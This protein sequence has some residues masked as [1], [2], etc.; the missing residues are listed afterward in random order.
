MI[1]KYNFTH[2]VDHFDYRNLRGHS[3]LHFVSDTHFGHDKEFLYRKRGYE[4]IKE[5]DADL[6]ERWNEEVRPEDSVIH[7]GDF[8][9]GAGRDSEQYCRD[10]LSSLNGKI[11]L[12]WGNHNAGLKQIFRKAIKTNYG[13]ADIEVYPISDPALPNVVFVGTN[14]LIKVKCL[15]LINQL[16]NSTHFVFCSHYAH[17]IWIDMNQGVMHVCGHSHGSDP[18]S[19][20]NHLVNKRLDVGIENFAT[21]ISFERVL[22]IMNSKQFVTLDHHD[23]RTSPSF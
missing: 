1:K 14:M 8:V 6:I 16:Q 2:T 11:Y 15:N 4:S 13:E 19:S 22:Q 18:E 3:R 5:H 17:R 21:P 12:L 23:A 20:E 9:V 10:I 7:C